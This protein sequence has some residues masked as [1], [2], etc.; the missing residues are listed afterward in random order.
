MVSVDL[1]V[2][3]PKPG[4]TILVHVEGRISLQEMHLVVD[5]LRE[6]WPDIQLLIVEDGVR[7]E[8]E[9]QADE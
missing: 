2:I 3:N 9:E 1:S 7:I 5:R 4:D 6:V 8:V